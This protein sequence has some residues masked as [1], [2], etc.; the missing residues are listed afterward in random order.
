MDSVSTAVK[1]LEAAMQNERIGYSFYTK[2][3]ELTKDE[4]GKKMFQALASDEQEHLHI[5]QT[6]ADSLKDANGWVS[7][8][9]AK[10]GR[11]P[12]SPPTLFPEGEDE[13]KKLIKRRTSDLDALDIAMEME[14]QSYN[15]YLK[16]GQKAK[17]LTAKAVYDYLCGEENNHFAVLQKTREYLASNGSWLY[18]DIHP[19]ML[20]G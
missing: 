5:L 14:K 1:A 2:A 13:V 17:D 12:S 15:R 19:P 8:E 4:K 20:D 18:D 10:R 11:K 6:Q 9:K 3:A 7:I 16:E